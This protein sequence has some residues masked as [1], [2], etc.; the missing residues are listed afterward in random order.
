VEEQR[1][2]IFFALSDYTRFNETNLHA[3]YNLPDGLWQQHASKSN[4]LI[5]P[6][7]QLVSPSTRYAQEEPGPRKLVNNKPGELAVLHSHTLGKL[8]PP[9][10]TQAQPATASE[11]VLRLRWANLGYLYHWGSK[12]YDFSKPT[13]PVPELIRLLSEQVVQEIDWSDVWSDSHAWIDG[14]A[15]W[16]SWGSQFCKCILSFLLSPPSTCN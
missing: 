15:E 11:L 13:Y 3:H 9:P 2:L 8:P 10:S 14:E 16:Q 4:A 5:Y 7:A 12:S 6:N 1:K